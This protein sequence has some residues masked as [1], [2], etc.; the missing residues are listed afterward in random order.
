MSIIEWHK[1]D[2]DETNYS[3]VIF[4]SE[5]D[6]IDRYDV[7]TET[8]LDDLICKHFYDDEDAVYY[9]VK[10]SKIIDKRIKKRFEKFLR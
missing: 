4:D 5:N 9:E 1:S 7:K 8:E 2:D 6:L 3:L 10:L